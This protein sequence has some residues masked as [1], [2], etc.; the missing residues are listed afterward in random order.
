[1]PLFGAHMSIAGGLFKAVESAREYKCQALQLFTANPQSWHVPPYS[2]KPSKAK[3][4][5]PPVANGDAGLSDE[6]VLA[7]RRALRGS[8]IRR[9]LSHDSYLVN[10]GSPDEAVYRR[11]IESFV[12]ELRRCEQL[13]LDYL[14]M[15]PGAHVDSGEEAGLARVA[16]ALN[17]V[18]AR[19][20]GYRV[21]VL[22]ETT[23]GQG[24]SLGY[25]FEHLAR[26][27]SMVAEP[28]RL[29]V[30]LD[31]CHVFAAG[32]ELAPRPCYLA[33]MR[34]FDRVVGLR[35]L[36]AFHL[37][38]SVKPLYSRVDRHAAIGQGHIGLEPFRFLVNDRRFRTRPMILETPKE[39]AEGNDLDKVNL[40]V[41]RGLVEGGQ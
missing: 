17:E 13:C 24:S 23:A 37:N 5:K 15:H 16:A 8:G 38:D 30:C 27:L 18:H 32:Y 19:C 40:K 35:R 39:D 21:K 22:L 9:T 3:S 41:L 11:S 20:P 28:N 10:L 1:M 4:A 26:I 14:V 25:R 6:I 7:F 2:A 34:E 31:T 33:T 36:C 29:G 12:A